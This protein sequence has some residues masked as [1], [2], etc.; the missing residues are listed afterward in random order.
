M[1]LL[2]Y[3]YK[4][5]AQGCT[6]GLHTEDAPKVEPQGAPPTQNQSHTM[7]KTE[8]GKEVYTTASAPTRPQKPTERTAAIPAAP[9]ASIKEAEADK[10]DPDVVAP[11]GTACKRA[12]CKVTFVS[13]E[14]NRNGDGP[15]TKCLY[16]PGAVR[17]FIFMY[18]YPTA[19]TT[20]RL[21][22]SIP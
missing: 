16:H 22:A 4:L 9:P 1:L 18:A 17:V 21:L 11:P 8:D 10:D 20:S 5:L 6:R 2:L 3:V 15:G 19:E 13:D 12:G 14:E 7:T